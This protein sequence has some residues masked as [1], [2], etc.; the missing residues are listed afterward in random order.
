[1]SLVAF[2]PLSSLPESPEPTTAA[3]VFAPAFEPVERLSSVKGVNV[4]WKPS[5]FL[6]D[7]LFVLE[8]HPKMLGA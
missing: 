1:M 2:K 8:G 5:C 3:K 6:F 4:V 7:S